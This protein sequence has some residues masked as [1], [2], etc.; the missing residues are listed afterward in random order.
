MSFNMQLAGPDVV[1]E[2]RRCGSVP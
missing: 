2:K 1:V